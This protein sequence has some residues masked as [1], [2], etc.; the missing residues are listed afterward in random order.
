MT[1]VFMEFYYLK[2]KD[3]IVSDIPMEFIE[4]ENK[5]GKWLVMNHLERCQPSA[6]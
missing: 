5:R 6:F 1:F 3:L 4:K 2:K